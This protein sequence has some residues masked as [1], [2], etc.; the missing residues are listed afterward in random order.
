MARGTGHDRFGIAKAVRSWGLR[1]LLCAVAAVV[2]FAVTAWLMHQLMDTWYILYVLFPATATVA[3]GF[4]AATWGGWHNGGALGLV[5][6][7]CGTVA[8][9]GALACIAYSAYHAA[10]I[11]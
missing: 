10:I 7:Y 8:A 1:S 5:G 2:L 6:R 9:L 4:L 3:L 11:L